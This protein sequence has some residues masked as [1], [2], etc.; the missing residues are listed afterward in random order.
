M[1]QLKLFHR[2][3]AGRWRHYSSVQILQERVTTALLEQPGLQMHVLI[4]LEVN[5]MEVRF[6]ANEHGINKKKKHQG[7]CY[8]FA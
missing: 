3:W 1:E 7:L 6:Q 4:I 8:P 5:S 2:N